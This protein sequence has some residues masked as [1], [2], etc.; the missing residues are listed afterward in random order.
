LRRKV[1]GER[2][3][4]KGQKLRGWEAGKLRIRIAD[5]DVYWVE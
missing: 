5:A 3:K 2:K 1:K 4:A